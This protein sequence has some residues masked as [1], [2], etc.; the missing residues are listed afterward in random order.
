MNSDVSLYIK[1]AEKWTL[2]LKLLRSILLDLELEEN[3]KWGVPTYSLNGKNI[4][5]ISGFNRYFAIWFHQGVLLKDKANVLINAQEGK[6]KALRQWRFNSLKELDKKMIQAYALEAINNSKKGKE[7]KPQKNNFPLH[8]PSQLNNMLN[9]D[10]VLK[11]NFELFS[12]SKK[13][14]FVAF[15]GEAKKEAT[16]QKRLHKISLLICKG[17]GLYDKYKK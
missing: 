11:E 13:R 16:K 14:E 17:E 3:I 1:N 2:E 15:I 8:I 4:L 5:G 7:V 10:L 6:T 12:L 9:N